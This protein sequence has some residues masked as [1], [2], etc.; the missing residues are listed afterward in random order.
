MS[1]AMSDCQSKVGPLEVLVD[2]RRADEGISSAQTLRL[3]EAG[4][5]HVF[6]SLAPMCCLDVLIT[7][8]YSGLLVCCAL[9]L[10]G[11]WQVGLG[12]RSSQCPTAQGFPNSGSTAL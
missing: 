12:A 8:S 5:Y 10:Q 4:I 11:T 1:E 3:P 9:F 2:L 6:I 7:H